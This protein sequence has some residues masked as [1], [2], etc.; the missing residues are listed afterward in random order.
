PHRGAA[1]F[2]PAPIRAYPHDYPVKS[3]H[4]ATIFK[5]V[6]GM[7]NRGFRR[8]ARINTTRVNLY[9]RAYPRNPWLSAFFDHFRCG[10]R[11]R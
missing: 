5:A 4:A 6:N 10:L 7:K 1:Q 11:R 8:Y 2:S 3:L 9:I